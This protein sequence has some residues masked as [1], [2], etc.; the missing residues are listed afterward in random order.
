[1]TDIGGGQAGPVPPPDDINSRLDEIAAEL[2]AESQFKEPSAAERARQLRP[3]PSGKP[4]RGRN[5]AKAAMLRQPVASRSEARAA[6][7]KSSRPRQRKRKPDSRTV[8]RRVTATLVAAVVVA[9]VP[10]WVAKTHSNGR[11]APRPSTPAARQPPFELADPFAGSP[12]ET[13]ADGAD[14][15]VAPAVRTPVGRYTVAEVQSAY[16]VVRQLLIAA[17]LDPATLAGGRPAAFLRLLTAQQRAS[18]ERDLR[19]TG[20]AKDG[21]ELSSR[22]WVTS[23]APGTTTLVGS[24]IKVHGSMRATT[25]VDDGT[26]ALRIKADYLFVYPVQQAHGPASTRLRIVQRRLVTFDFATWDNPGGALEPWLKDVSGD[27][28]NA[29]CDATDGYVHPL[30][31][32]GPEPRTRPSGKPIDPYNQSILP[33]DERCMAVTDT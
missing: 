16:A 25:A 1:M 26:H 6:K 30:F 4:V 20:L 32:A 2:A 24:I 33:P 28:A 18:V 27:T 29:S 12:A 17:N 10:Y 3:G 13:F 5:A 15:I 22:S 19:K 7:A 14:G 31:P 8:R 23:F 21:T 11:S 9:A